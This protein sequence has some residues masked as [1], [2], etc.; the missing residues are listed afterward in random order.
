MRWHGPFSLPSCGWQSLQGR[1]VFLTPASKNSL[2][3]TTFDL[4]CCVSPTSLLSWHYLEFVDIYHSQCQQTSI[5]TRH[6]LPRW[7][8][9]HTVLI[10]AHPRLNICI[11]AHHPQFICP[12]PFYQSEVFTRFSLQSGWKVFCGNTA[13]RNWCIQSTCWKPSGKK[14]AMCEW[15]QWGKAWIPCPNKNKCVLKSRCRIPIQEFSCPCVTRL[16]TR[17]QHYKNNRRFKVKKNH[18]EKEAF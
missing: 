12:Q 8:Q 4:W 16:K 9:V 17:G 5:G 15:E 7:G 6:T 3:S 2:T 18:T 14:N 10:I 11:V 13:L 1:C